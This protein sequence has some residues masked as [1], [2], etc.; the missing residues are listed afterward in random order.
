MAPTAETT[1]SEVTIRLE[2]PLENVQRV[3]YESIGVSAE[4]AG[5]NCTGFSVVVEHDENAWPPEIVE[6]AR[7][8]VRDV[9]TLIGVGRGVEI[10][11][12]AA[13]IRSLLPAR[14]TQ[15]AAV[16]TTQF[17]ALLTR[18][19][20][21]LPAESLVER[22]AGDHRLRRQCEALNA[23]MVSDDL[24]SVISWSYKVLEQEKDRKEGYRP[25]GSFRHIRNAVSHPELGDKDAKRYFQSQLDVDFPDMRNPQHLG[26]LEA[27]SSYLRKEAVRIVESRL[28]SAKFWK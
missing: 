3:T 8:A 25:D 15:S 12:G 10:P 28:S 16:T 2:A 1:K 6:K 14:C 21:A 19:L 24:A 22:L 5:G 18:G 20:K 9:L 11:I 7:I 4:M 23:A 26:F 13:R 27:K 17:G